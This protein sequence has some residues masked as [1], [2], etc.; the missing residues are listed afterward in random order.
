MRTLIA[1]WL[2]CLTAVALIAPWIDVWAGE[3]AA[4]R[5]CPCAGTWVK[6]CG[7]AFAESEG[8][9]CAPLRTFSPICGMR[10]A[11]DHEPAATTTPEVRD[12][13]I[14]GVTWKPSAT[15]PQDACCPIENLART[16]WNTLYCWG[17]HWSQPARSLARVMDSGMSAGVGSDDQPPPPLT[18]D[19]N[20]SAR[21]PMG[22]EWE[23]ELVWDEKQGVSLLVH[24]KENED[25]P[26]STARVHTARKPEV[27]PLAEPRRINVRPEHIQHDAELE[28][29]Q[30]QYRGYLGRGKVHEA[31]RVAEQFMAMATVDAD[32]GD[33]QVIS[34]TSAD[35]L[36]RDESEESTPIQG[37][38]IRGSHGIGTEATLR[39]VAHWRNTPTPP[40]RHPASNWENVARHTITCHFQGATLKQVADFFEQASGMTV[41]VAPGSETQAPAGIHVFCRNRGLEQALRVVL[42]TCDLGY[43]VEGNE[44]SIAPSDV[45][46]T[47]AEEN[48][49]SHHSTHWIP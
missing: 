38:G 26:A 47:R 3:P 48:S 24:P 35:N 12:L 18:Q 22:G 28:I 32:S 34:N 8:S 5:F 46:R 19:S 16:C 36:P 17:R 2:A 39:A 23:F 29:L 42:G 20:V 41:Q 10:L 25:S 30:R 44:I 1:R 45:I 31:L 21:S 33:S 27:V 37:R 13:G 9:T 11:D 4:K 49:G 7:G 40:S 43:I 14:L 15:C 6:D